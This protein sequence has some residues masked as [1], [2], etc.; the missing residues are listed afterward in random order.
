M[1]LPVFNPHW[2]NAC[3]SCDHVRHV[4]WSAP[5]QRLVGVSWHCA[6]PGGGLNYPKGD[7][8]SASLMRAEGMPCGPEAALHKV[9]VNA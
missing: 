4:P 6:A 7:E 3:A 9:A 1:S 8:R 5:Q 2:R